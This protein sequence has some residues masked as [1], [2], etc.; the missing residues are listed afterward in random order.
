MLKLY[1][2]RRGHDILCTSPPPQGQFGGT[3]AIA[4][5]GGR[6]AA[7]EHGLGALLERSGGAPFRGWQRSGWQRSRPR[8]ASI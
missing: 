2:A 5:A 3:V 1:Y 7:E 6:L 4:V 8:P